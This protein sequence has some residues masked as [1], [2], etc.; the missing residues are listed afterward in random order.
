MTETPIEQ[1]SGA[2]AEL[3]ASLRTLPTGFSRA[4]EEAVGTGR[5]YVGDATLW[6]AA[7]SG[8]DSLKRLW[9]N[10]AAMH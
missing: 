5:I 4:L 2:L 7:F 10:L 3:N 6:S 1:R 9:L 8:I